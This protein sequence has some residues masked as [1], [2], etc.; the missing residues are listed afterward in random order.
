MR[1]RGQQLENRKGLFW[2][3]V[4]CG[5]RDERT[6]DWS[7]RNLKLSIV[8]DEDSEWKIV[9]VA[10]AIN[11]TDDE[12]GVGGAVGLF[13]PKSAKPRLQLSRS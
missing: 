4:R 3:L 6:Y 12:L 5:V 2:Q 10:A 7:S 8:I 1:G 11:R 13:E 9:V